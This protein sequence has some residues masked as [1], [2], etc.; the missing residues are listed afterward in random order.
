[1]AGRARDRR[2]LEEEVEHVRMGFAR[3]RERL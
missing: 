3:H 1:L 2:E